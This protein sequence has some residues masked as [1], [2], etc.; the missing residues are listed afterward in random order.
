[1]NL[2]KAAVMIFF[3]LQ[4]HSIWE[5]SLELSKF[6][7]WFYLIREVEMFSSYL[8][9]LQLHAKNVRKIAQSSEKVVTTSKTTKHTMSTCITVT[10]AIADFKS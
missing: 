1:M 3:S 7:S 8:T 5:H 6:E 2:S 9:R 4:H 10:P